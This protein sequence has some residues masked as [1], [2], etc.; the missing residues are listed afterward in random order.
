V[1]DYYSGIAGKAVSRDK[2]D[3]LSAN[4]REQLIS[5]AISDANFKKVND[6]KAANGEPRIERD[7]WRELTAE[8]QSTSLGN[9]IKEFE[10]KHIQLKTD[11]T[12]EWVNREYFFNLPFEERAYLEKHGVEGYQDEYYIELKT[13]GELI[14]KDSYGALSGEF[15]NILQSSGTAGLDAHIEKNYITNIKGE[16]LPKSWYN[17]LTPDQKA[18]A[19]EHTYGQYI[20]NY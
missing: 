6:L 2:W 4:N 15:Q 19:K 9:E 3:T 8:Q 10:D 12:D 16:L 11:E 7:E 14:K 1:Y 17:E 13:T 5:R 20:D 18:F